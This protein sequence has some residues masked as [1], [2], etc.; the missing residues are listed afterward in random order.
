MALQADEDVELRTL[1]VVNNILAINPSET[2][3]SHVP[4]ITQLLTSCKALL[5]SSQTTSKKTKSDA[6]VAVHRFKTKVSSL[7]NDRSFEA[8][9]AASILVKASIEA[10]G[11]EMLKDCKVWVN[12][13]IAVLKKPDPPA[14]KKNSMVALTRIF[15]LTKDYPTLVREVT[16]P[17][18]PA[19]IT[20]CLNHF[21]DKK[22]EWAIQQTLYQ[23]ELLEYMLETFNKLIPRYPTIFRTFAS[24][25]RAIAILVISQSTFRVGDAGTPWRSP[26]SSQATKM[27]Q[28]VFVQLHICAPKNGFAEQ[29]NSTHELILGTIHEVA[30][31][32]FRGVLE[33]WT[34]AS[35][36][37]RPSRSGAT[38][39]AEPHY[40][41]TDALGNP[42]WSGLGA[43]VERMISLLGLL[44][45]YFVTPTPEPVSPRLGLVCSLLTR[46]FS[47][48]TPRPGDAAQFQGV[49]RYNKQVSRQER[50]EF[51]VSL[52]RIHSAAILI[53]MHILRRFGPGSMPMCPQFFDQ[54]VWVFDT[55]HSDMELREVTYATLGFVLRIIGPSL[56]SGKVNQLET[57][58][59]YCAAD[60]TI[61]ESITSISQRTGPVLQKANGNASTVDPNTILEAPAVVTSTTTSYDDVQLAARLLISIVLSKVPAGAISQQMREQLDSA[62]VFS[63]NASAMTGSVLNPPPLS[64]TILPAMAKI[65]PES[66]QV[67]AILRPRMPIMRSG[68]AEAAEGS[69]ANG[70]RWS[71]AAVSK[72]P[73]PSSV[74]MPSRDVEQHSPTPEAARR[75]GLN[76][77]EF[78]PAWDMP[79]HLHDDDRVSISTKQSDPDVEMNAE[80]GS[81]GYNRAVQDH[82]PVLEPGPPLRLAELES[83]PEQASITPDGLSAL[84]A[85]IDA[86][87]S[88]E[89]QKQPAREIL[90][91]GETSSM[92]QVDL[93]GENDS[94][95]GSDDFEIPSLVFKDADEGDGDEDNWL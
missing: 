1:N 79:P 61:S 20:A 87:S 73:M 5:S 94:D 51:F 83:T 53:V 78:Q 75:K 26:A 46:I 42:G 14:S 39:T 65:H 58:L 43:G 35:N 21:Q 81:V 88:P 37:P 67:E 25:I 8:R 18:L 85:A 33:T 44:R 15:M 11:W 48:T 40:S 30:N 91:V 31:Q 4:R 54:L 57:I 6:A 9:W 70:A 55:E 36:M 82:Q 77:P 76:A 56:T 45:Q 2:L 50:E 84:E 60:A 93:K 66:P 29:W 17:S 38:L 86:A 71:T 27:A 10:G 3:P 32:I 52:P 59:K 47:V 49:E 34:T 64:A 12:G 7:L 92:Q 41:Q 68:A 13:L 89:R 24:Q 95:D 16:T 69:R 74:E 63:G 19:F 22:A 80:P 62:A 23:R 90:E 72:P 28:R